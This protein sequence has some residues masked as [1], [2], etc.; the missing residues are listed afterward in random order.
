MS[1]QYPIRIQRKRTRGWK[2]PLNTV[3]VGRPTRWGNPWRVGDSMYDPNDPR[4]DKET[5]FRKCETVADTVEAFRRCVDK[6]LNAPSYLRTEDSILEISGGYSN[7]IHVHRPSIQK[8]LRGKNLACW[9]PLYDD[10]GKPVPCHA[11][12]LL[13]LA[14][15][16]TCEEVNPWRD[17]STLAAK[18]GDVV[19]IR[20]RDD[21]DVYV[22]DNVFLRN[23]EVPFA[24]SNEPDGD[25][26][27]P[28]QNGWW[29][30]H[31]RRSHV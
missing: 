29:I 22:F 30:T 8:F 17:I 13:A 2:M 11:D 19:D 24:F 16:P 1:Q 5:G 25:V 12:V 14:N 18:V 9:C 7:D 20:G 6:D 31:W 10:E 28:H 15:K 4:A 27:W 3:Y 21:T 23:E 26:Y